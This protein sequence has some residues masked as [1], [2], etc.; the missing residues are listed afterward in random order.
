MSCAWVAVR[1]SVGEIFRFLLAVYYV[2]FGLKYSGGLEVGGLMFDVGCFGFV[3][4]LPRYEA[5]QRIW[6]GEIALAI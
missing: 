5:S 2:G 1:S 4:V 3:F 6:I